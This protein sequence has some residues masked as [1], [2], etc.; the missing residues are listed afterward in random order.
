MEP[1]QNLNGAQVTNNM[2]PEQK[3]NGALIGSMIIIIIL[4]IG[5]IYLWKTEF[6]AK[7]MPV[8]P[9]ETPADSTSMQGTEEQTAADTAEIEYELNNI[10]LETLDE[11]L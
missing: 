1:E 2:V 6:K 11:G 4:I 10:N 9:E 3:S 7:P 8:I 5:G